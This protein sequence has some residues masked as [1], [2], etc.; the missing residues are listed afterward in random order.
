MI[1]PYIKEK[2]SFIVDMNKTLWNTN[3]DGIVVQNPQILTNEDDE[4]IL[5]AVLGREYEIYNYLINVLF[6]KSNNIIII[7]VKDFKPL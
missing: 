3:I 7:K 1:L 2:I 5:I 4:K 6:I